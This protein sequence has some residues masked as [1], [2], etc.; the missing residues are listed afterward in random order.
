[1][2]EARARVEV[3]RLVDAKVGPIKQQVAGVQVDITGRL[4]GQKQQLD[5]VQNRLEAQ[6]ESLAPGL[7][8]GIKL[9][10]VKL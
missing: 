7:V 9:P 10:A 6:L 2:A 3:D 8:P 5:E 4:D 1:M